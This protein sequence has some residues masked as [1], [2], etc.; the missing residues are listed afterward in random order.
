MLCI[1]SDKEPTPRGFPS[2]AV[3]VKEAF[4]IRQLSVGGKG[5]A[6]NQSYQSVVPSSISVSIT[7]EL[8]R[9]AGSWA[10]RQTC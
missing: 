9:N 4:S 2:I 10:P 6:L 5:N 7:W 1:I 8:V 3:L